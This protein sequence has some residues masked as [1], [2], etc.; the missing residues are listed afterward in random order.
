MRYPDFFIVGAPKCGTTALYRYLNF[1]PDVFLP[2]LKE[3]QYYCSDFPGLLQV[4]DSEAYLS[5]FEAAGT[6]QIVGEA[7]VWYLYSEVA[8]KRIA[9]DVPDAKIV[10][11]VRNPVDA[12]HSLH[13]QSVMSLREDIDDI[14]EAWDAQKLRQANKQLPYYCP[15][16][17]LLSYAEVYRYVEQVKRFQEAFGVNQ[18]KVIV[19]EEFIRDVRGT[20]V[21]VLEFIGADPSRFPDVALDP[22][23]E[24]RV[25]RS[26]WVADLLRR[27]PNSFAPVILRMRAGF[28]RLGIRPV[29][30][31]NFFATRTAKRAALPEGV[32]AKIAATY[33]DEVGKLEGLLGR[34][35]EHW[36]S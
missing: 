9:Q 22:V 4:R 3:P 7:S 36:K 34:K 20:V 23:N 27:P 17:K 26:E 29:E 14:E 15:E 6:D 28:R 24:S 31:I 8:A 21:D 13:N 18:V 16:P 10:V 5:L 30:W 35:L 1:H 19:F 25:F 12:V 2:E 33:E 11:L 32:S